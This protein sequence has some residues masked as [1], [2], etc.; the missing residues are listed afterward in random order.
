MATFYVDTT[1]GNDSNAGAITTPWK[2][3]GKAI[4][5]SGAIGTGGDT[6]YVAPGTYREIISLGITPTV[7]TNVIGDF[8]LAHASSPTSGQY[9]FGVRPGEIILS[10]WTT[11]DTTAPSASSLL[12]LNSK[13]FHT[14]Q[15]I[16]FL[17]GTGVTIDGQSQTA[18][19]DLTFNDCTFYN[20]GNNDAVNMWAT[21]GIILHWH[22]NRCIFFV[23]GNGTAHYS[24]RCVQNQT[25][26]AG[27]QDITF[28]N[29]LSIN[30]FN[31]AHIEIYGTGSAAGGQVV[32][33]TFIG[34]GDAVYSNNV[35][36]TS[37][38]IAVRN[39]LIM[40]G[41]GLHSATSGQLVED[42]NVI[43]SQTP[44]TNVSTGTHSQTG[45]YQALLEL[46]QA[47]KRGA[48]TLRPFGEPVV[49]SPLLGFGTDGTYNT[50]VDGLNRPRPAGGGA[51]TNAV[52]AFERGST[53]ILQ[54]TTVHTGGGSAVQ[55]AG[56][57]YHDFYAN[58]DAAAVTVTVWA[59][60]DTASQQPTATI[61]AEPELGLASD[62]SMTWSDPGTNAWAQ[63]TATITPTAA[64]VITIRVASA[65]NTGNA[66]FDD[67][68]FA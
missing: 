25:P 46:G 65:N 60:Y 13:P 56:P 36:S 45:T 3:I 49:S 35:W 20:I 2:T 43:W 18:S 37:T 22:F 55:I 41:S 7:M 34:G 67:F 11:N 44:R 16:V 31:S 58:V 47:L 28:Y 24:A 21:S 10:A 27:D 1:N 64:G 59:R 53:G 66:F 14:F 40:T 9:G 30:N 38:P 57:G 33:C 39:C 17:G 26:G 23:S 8:A 63:F 19:H 4:G 62:T 29:C 15:N 32:N 12:S 50:S 51:T 52:G 42:Y 6:V 5:A 54:T 48:L 61:K 68:G